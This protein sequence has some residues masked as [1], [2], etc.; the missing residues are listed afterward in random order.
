M[1]MYTYVYVCTH[2]HMH[3]HVHIRLNWNAYWLSHTI[4][5][6]NYTVSY[7]DVTQGERRLKGTLRWTV[8]EGAPW[9]AEMVLN[10]HTH[11]WFPSY[12]ST[13]RLSIWR[14]SQPFSPPHFPNFSSLTLSFPFPCLPDHASVMLNMFDSFGGGW[15]S[16]YYN[17]LSQDGKLLY[18]G[19]LP[20]QGE[21]ESTNEL[22]LKKDQCSIIMLESLG[23]ISFHSFLILFY[24]SHP[25]IYFSSFLR[26][27]SI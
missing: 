1:H 18:G 8:K 21:K 13:F 4:S 24:H 14:S 27:F 10:R 2:T 25:F 16:A 11:A 22:C 26:F 3:T 20:P 7:R 23:I 19:N 12:T 5:T 9:H 6:Y 17:V 15:D